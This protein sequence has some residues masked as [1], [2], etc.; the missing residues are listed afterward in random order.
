MKP[1]IGYVARCETLPAMIE[2][3]VKSVRALERGLDVLIEIQRCRAASLHELHQRLG[4]PKAT[5]LRMLVTLSGRGL[6]WQRLADGAYLP[7]MLRGPPDRHADA[8]AR[9]AEVASPHLVSLSRRVAWP[10]VLAVPRLDH[11]EIIET[12]S[13]L[14]RLDAAILG[15]VGAKLSYIHTATGRAYLAACPPS[16]RAAILARLRPAD[17]TAASIAALDAILAEIGVRGWSSRDPPHP[18]P[19]RSRA[20]VVRDGRRSIAVPIRVAGQP[21][22]AVNITWPQRRMSVDE[23]VARHLPTLR[24]TAETIGRALEPADG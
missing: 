20:D 16:E 3:K 6:I 12:T 8:M 22:A 24:A 11:V 7:S 13:A 10:S 21:I 23:I 2:R 9:L 14:T 1:C 5:L 19:D 18:W 4:L 17:A 15:P